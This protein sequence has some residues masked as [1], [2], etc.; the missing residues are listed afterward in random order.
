[1]IAL[2]P[3][4]LSLVSPLQAEPVALAGT[5]WRNPRDSVHV[6]FESCG[7]QLCGTVVWASD[8]AIADAARGSSTPLV[9]TRIFRDFHADGANVWRGKVHVPDLGQD[10]S[11]RITLEGDRMTGRGCLIAGLVCKSQTWSRVR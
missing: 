4:F 10:F 11:G 9:G 6:R 1:M 5:I 7:V 3:F 2:L 8:K